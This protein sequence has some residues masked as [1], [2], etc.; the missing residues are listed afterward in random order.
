MNSVA[1]LNQRDPALLIFLF[2]TSQL[3][4][5]VLAVFLLHTFVRFMSLLLLSLLLPA[6]GTILSHR[7]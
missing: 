3:C 2:Q 4:V 5:V 7:R 6:H 1:V